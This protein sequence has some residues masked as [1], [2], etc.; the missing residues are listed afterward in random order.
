MQQAINIFWFKRD[1]RLEDNEALFLACNEDKPL[2]IVYILE[3]TLTSESHT[4]E[5]HLNF[6]KESL[7]DLN[8]QLKSFK[9]KILLVEDEVIPTFEKLLTHFKLPNFSALK[10]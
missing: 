2:L 10:K 9:T 1:L 5:R 8:V 6:I 7:I 3:P 4:S